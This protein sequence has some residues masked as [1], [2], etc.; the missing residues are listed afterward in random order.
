MI[1]PAHQINPSHHNCAIRLELSL[2]TLAPR[3][4]R[5][6]LAMPREYAEI[7]GTASDVRFA[8]VQRGIIHSDRYGETIAPQVEF[9]AALA[10]ARIISRINQ[11]HRLNSK[12]NDVSSPNFART[13]NNMNPKVAE[14]QAKR[15]K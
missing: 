7:V 14:G 1:A 10:A 15:P 6:V 2:L 4:V 3:R 8:I 5:D 12:R 11:R 9:Y 13:G